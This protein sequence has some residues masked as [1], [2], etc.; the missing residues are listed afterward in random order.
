MLSH[1]WR[2]FYGRASRKIRRMIRL[3]WLN[4]H[5]QQSLAL[6]RSSLT[7]S[8]SPFDSWAMLDRHRWSLKDGHYLLLGCIS[9]WALYIMRDV[10]LLVKTLIGVLLIFVLILPITSQF[11]L[12][13]LPIITWLLLLF[14]SRYAAN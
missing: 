3:S 10:G 9:I 6:S 7:S 14:S 4:Y 5:S 1:M 2:P 12:P 13:F 11:F 8:Y